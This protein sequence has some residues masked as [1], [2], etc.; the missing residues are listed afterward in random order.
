MPAQGPFLNVDSDNYF[1]NVHRLEDKAPAETLRK[2]VRTLAKAGCRS[3]A[4]CV[5]ARRCV[6]ESEAWE[7]YWDGFDPAQ[8]AEQP[9]FGGIPK[10]D[11][12]KWE[13]LIRKIQDFHSRGLDYPKLALDFAREE[14]ISPWLSV[15]MNDIHY[16]AQPSHPFHGTFIKSHPEFMRRC[17]KENYFSHALDYGRTEVRARFSALI[18]ELLERYDMDGLE[19]DFMREPFLFSEGEEAKGMRTLNAW[20]EH[21]IAPM[22]EKASTR[23]GRKVMLGARVP[24]SPDVASSLGLDVAGWLENG[25]FDFIAPSPRWA[26]IEFE[27]PWESWLGLRPPRSETR[28][29]AGMEVLYGPHP[30]AKKTQ[31][32]PSLLRGAASAALSSGADGIY[33]FNFFPGGHPEWPEEEFVSTLKDASSLEGLLK[34]PRTHAI[35]FRDI[36]KPGEEPASQLPFAKESGELRLFAAPIAKGS[37]LLLKAEFRGSSSSWDE[38]PEIETLGKALRLSCREANGNGLL[39]ANYGFKAWEEISG[40]LPV[41]IR[42]GGATPHPIESLELEVKP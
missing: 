22:V 25:L 12:G 32:S 20:L 13:A 8:G 7:S 39:Q 11:A 19:L 23:A 31:V 29:F 3:A 6:F 28:L 42:W 9:F 16:G 36:N 10:A 38:A 17:A 37:E 30:S 14:G 2:Y 34:K 41:K 24:S 40:A 21:E 1:F 4:F 5:C 35:S 26:T 15:R 33:F 27:M 18:E